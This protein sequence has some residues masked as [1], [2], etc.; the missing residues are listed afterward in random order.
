MTQRDTIRR[1]DI[2]IAGRRLTI[3]TDRDTEVLESICDYVNARY[4]EVQATPGLSQA[5]QSV[6]LALCIAEDL[7]AERQLHNQ[8]IGRVRREA[9][10]ILQRLENLTSPAEPDSE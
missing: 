10:Q 6:M 1:Q 3:Q 2:H 8:K 4:N 5:N 7:F 9:N